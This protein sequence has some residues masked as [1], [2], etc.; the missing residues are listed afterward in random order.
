[1]QTQGLTA[2]K[3]KPKKSR[4]KD[5]KPANEKTLA[6]PRINKPKKTFHQDKKKKYLKKKRDWKNST[7]ATEVT[8]IKG[9]KK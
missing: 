8:A 5:L 9:K 6:L 7:P 3:S 2:K 1:M 4:P